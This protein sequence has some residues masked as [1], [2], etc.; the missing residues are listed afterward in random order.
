MNQA[1]V[2]VELEIDM[3]NRIVHGNTAEL[4]FW[5]GPLELVHFKFKLLTL[6]KVSPD[7][8]VIWYITELRQEFSLN[9]LSLFGGAVSTSTLEMFIDGKLGRCFLYELICLTCRLGMR[10]RR[11]TIV[12][13][14]CL[15]DFSSADLVDFLIRSMIM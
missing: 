15:A 10:D 11:P 13:W 14:P 2:W 7:P 3:E 5:G 12:E 9:Y 6:N 8:R 4:K 1:R